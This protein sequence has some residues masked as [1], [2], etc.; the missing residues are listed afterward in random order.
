M[1]LRFQS[2]FIEQKIPCSAL[3]IRFRQEKLQGWIVVSFL[4]ENVKGQVVADTFHGGDGVLA[5]ASG[6]WLCLY[7]TDVVTDLRPVKSQ[8]HKPVRGCD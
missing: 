2:H 3:Q 7:N 4:S 8:H 6:L 1:P 5:Y